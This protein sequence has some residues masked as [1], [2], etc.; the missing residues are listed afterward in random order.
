MAR[1]AVKNLIP[2]GV[3]GLG[4]YPIL[5]VSL[6][7]GLLTVAYAGPEGGIVR[8][9]SAQITGQGNTTLIQQSS[10]R[11]IIDWRSFGIQADERVQ[12]AQPS[13][14]SAT[15]NRVT[16]DRLS[17]ILGRMDANGQ[18]LLIN[19]NGVV[20]GQSAQINVGSL[21]AGTANISN[22][23]FL[24]G[25]LLFDQP[26]KPGAGIINSG[27]I[28]AAEGGLVALVAPHVRNDGLIQA[29]LGKVI[30]GAADTFTIDL[31]GDG[32]VNLALSEVSLAA[33]KD[34]QGLP[35]KSLISQNG[36]IDVGSGKAVLVTAETAKGVLDS[37]INMSGAILAD[38]AVKEGGRIL[39]LARGGNTDVSGQLSAQGTKGGQIDVLGDQVHLFSTAKLAANGDYGGGTVRVGGAYQGSGDTYRAQSTYIDSGATLLANA[40]VRGSGGEVVVWSNGGTSFAGGIEARGGIEAGDG[41]LVEVSGKQSLLFN[42]L[43]DAGA[44]QGRAGSLLLDPY[45]FTIGRAEASLINRVLRTGTSTSVSADND[46]FVNYTIDGRGR[47]A[48][49]G[50]TLT[51]GNN[52]NVNDNIITN[53][54]AINLFTTA[55]SLNLTSGK[56]VYAGTSPIT[57][58]SGGTLTN[59]AYLIGG[60]LSLISTQGSISINQGIDN[61]ATGNLLIQAAGDVNVNQ[62]I[63]SLNDGDGVTVTAGND[64]NVNA[65]IDGRPA[66]GSNPNG[67]VTM[68]AGRDIGLNKSILAGAINLTASLGTINAPTMTAGAVTL[69]GNGIPHG[70]GLFAGTGPISVTASGNLSS[71]VYVT[72]GPVSIRSTGG[73]VNVDTKLAEI[74]GNVTIQADAGS[75]NIV[76][77]IANM[78]SGSNLTV[79]AGTDINLSRQI[80]AL[81]DSNPLSITPVPGGSVTFAAGRD[82]LIND[83]LATNNGAVSITGGRTVIQQADGL[84][85]FGAPLTKQVR[86]GNAAISVASGG[87]LNFGSLVTT[88]ALNV[89]ST[90]GNVN[91]NVP[92]YET[93]GNTT[94]TAAK[95][96]NINQVA[97]NTT[98][99]SNLTM[100]S[101]GGQINVDAKVGPWDRATGET[102]NRN[103]LPGGS[104]TLS[105]YGNINVHTDI[106]SYKGALTDENAAVIRLNAGT[107]QAAGTVNLQDGIKVMSDSGAIHVTAFGDLSNGPYIN[108]QGISVVNGT[109]AT[110]YFT[111][112]AL[113]LASTAGNLTINQTI[114]DTTG[115]VTLQ[116]GN[117]IIV[118]QRIYSNSA[119]ISLL[120]GP[121]GIFMTPDPDPKPGP[122][123]GTGVLSDTDARGGNLTLVAEGNIYPSLL[124]TYGTL[125]VKST[126][127]VISGGRVTSSRRDSGSTYPSLI[128]LAGSLGISGFN[129]ENSRN[130][131]AISDRG[132]V[133][134]LTVFFPSSLDVIAKENINMTGL[135]GNAN[136]YAGRDINNALGITWSGNITEKAGGNIT[137]GNLSQTTIGGGSADFSYIVNSLNLSAGTNPFATFS[138]DYQIAGVF[139][140][141]L[142]DAWT[143]AGLGNISVSKCAWIEGEGGLTATA[144]GNIAMDTIHVS[145]SLMPVENTTDPRQAQQPLSLTAGGNINLPAR[146]ET[147]GPVT[148]MSQSG[149]INIGQTIGAHVSVETPDSHIWNPNDKG[150]ASLAITA[151]NGNITMQEARAEGDITIKAYGNG[152]T[153]GSITFGPGIQVGAGTSLLQ[154]YIYDTLGVPQLS[155]TYIPVTDYATTISAATVDRLPVPV[156]VLP[157]IGPGPTMSG[158]GAPASPGALPPGLPVAL[159][160][161]PAQS[162]DVVNVSGGTTPA[163]ST[164]APEQVEPLRAIGTGGLGEIVPEESASSDEEE[165]KKVLK[166]SGGRGAGQ[167]ADFGRR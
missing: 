105:A 21:I 42:G 148:L 23:N 44:S 154:E 24:E 117:G 94:I 4:L 27:S 100:T 18:V 145:Y 164:G 107:S 151:N 86:A 10:P 134:G 19:P 17:I 60:P 79:T 90:A 114:P 46:M 95:D 119:D 57:L 80:D 163:T 91:I 142:K 159:T 162:P 69:D 68:T 135:L 118:N 50:L 111:T 2:G 143:S 165:G 112:G 157:A 9:G 110:G 133:E 153:T 96:I 103:A 123:P 115:K 26:G 7:V 76:Q 32:L 156:L 125:T 109:P 56:V 75:V 11:A 71:G 41:G 45:D 106:A 22:E 122:D 85:T 77:E 121:G 58:R 160:A 124:R 66:P 25:K 30:L 29:R 102:L 48:G 93:T 13:S 97:A 72:T 38:S 52:L 36:T 3:F 146:I 88:G 129:T 141:P 63:V 132:S 166:F 147:M 150:V 136:L 8:A 20:F 62:P 33:L 83:H 98:S 65:Q 53:N 34:G 73:N 89:A 92:I 6:I 43:V 137:V 15:L 14:S 49:G 35:I 152:S 144:T 78:R 167:E 108:D 101:T 40:R 138:D 74:L 130:I 155:Y 64:I 120:A 5:T 70:E 127:G 87:D 139:V 55:G 161:L 99:G 128:E 37:L 84:D 47:Y 126:D 54:G 104:I 12:F 16:G 116:G 81:D 39:L 113:N 140:K 59:A 61:S 28:T 31:Y 158:P 51:A 149:N 82:V 1:C 67:A 131:K